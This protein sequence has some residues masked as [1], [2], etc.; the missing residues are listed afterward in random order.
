M[1]G[2]NIPNDVGIQAVV[3]VAQLVSN[4]P[5]VPPGYEW[6]FYLHIVWNVPYGFRD[7][8]NGALDR[9]P[10]HRICCNI[11][12]GLAYQRAFNESDAP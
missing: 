11:A 7:D 9:K 10:E 1:L 8:L 12:N 4:G 6:M 3:L 2:R 5:N